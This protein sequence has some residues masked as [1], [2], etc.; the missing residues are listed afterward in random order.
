MFDWVMTG[1]SQLLQR[2]AFL[3]FHWFTKSKVLYHIKA[4]GNLLNIFKYISADSK[5]NRPEVKV[6]EVFNY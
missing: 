3:V 6:V 5:N 4:G 1:S 2:I